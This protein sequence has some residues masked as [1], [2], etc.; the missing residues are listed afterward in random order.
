MSA[1]WIE[2]LWP[3]GLESEGSHHGVEEDLQEDHV[4]SV[5]WLHDLDPLDGHLVL[6]SVVLCLVDREV[7]ALAETV[8]AGP[9][10]DEEL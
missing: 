3:D 10:V 7:S 5:G 1:G 8:D 9:P 2:G 6:G 4:V